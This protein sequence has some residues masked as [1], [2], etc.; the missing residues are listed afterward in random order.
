MQTSKCSQT[1]CRGTDLCLNVKIKRLKV[2]RQPFNFASRQNCMKEQCFSSQFICCLFYML[3][4]IWH[5]S[6]TIYPFYTLLPQAAVQCYTG[7]ARCLYGLG[8]NSTLKWT[9]AGC[10]W[11]LPL[12]L[13]ILHKL[14]ER[15]LS[16]SDSALPCC[17]IF[18]FPLPFYFLSPLLMARAPWEENQESERVSDRQTYIELS[19][20]ST[21]PACGLKTPLHSLISFLWPPPGARSRCW[22]IGV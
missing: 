9:E 15:W 8:I 14:M 5:P 11:K 19:S 3:I 18:P 10:C 12:G 13:L 6:L 21:F 22:S 1:N 2:R 16:S 20:Q 7:S 4:L 17:T